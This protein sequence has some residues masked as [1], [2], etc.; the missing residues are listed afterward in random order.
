[1]FRLVYL[2]SDL[3]ILPLLADLQAKREKTKA[4]DLDQIL[5]WADN[6]AMNPEDKNL[7]QFPGLTDLRF[8][9]GKIDFLE[10][11]NLLPLSLLV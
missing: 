8:S 10:F 2:E 5:S 7:W 6:S 4:S 9:T 1:M 11:V 3:R